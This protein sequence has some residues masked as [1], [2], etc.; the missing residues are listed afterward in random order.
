MKGI[1]MSSKRKIEANQRNSLKS[2]GPRTKEGKEIVS[3]NALKHGLYSKKSPILPEEDPKEYQA[4]LNSL[5]ET[6]NPANEE[7]D[8]FVVEMAQVMMEK[9]RLNQYK[10]RVIEKQQIKKLIELKEMQKQA[11]IE[12]NIPRKVETCNH[13]N[14]CIN[15]VD[16]VLLKYLEFTQVDIEAREDLE[17]AKQDLERLLLKDPDEHLWDHFI[18]IAKKVKKKGKK[19]KDVI[20]GIESLVNLIAERVISLSDPDT[21]L[22]ALPEVMTHSTQNNEHFMPISE[23]ARWVRDIYLVLSAIGII[24]KKA[25][26]SYPHIKCF[27]LKIKR[28]LEERVDNITR[29]INYFHNLQEIK[30]DVELVGIDLVP[31]K[32]SWN[33]L[34]RM[35]THLDNRLSR[36]RFE[37]E[38][39]QQ[40]RYR[41]RLRRI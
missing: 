24:T 35:E 29:D 32:S 4:L 28:L 5:Q 41:R 37:L 11:A 20:I 10:I 23:E 12:Q 13:L 17:K 16:S 8:L 14:Y 3:R 19:K 38:C 15:E 2:T 39:V 34:I 36:L 1:P 9:M 31:Y 21:I 33:A 40:A 27:L 25:E 22:Q 26:V 30:K 18:G 6:Y 7:E